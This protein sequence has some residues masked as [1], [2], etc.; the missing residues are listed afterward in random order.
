LLIKTKPET[1]EETVSAVVERESSNSKSDVASVMMEVD[2]YLAY[3]RFSQAES[4]I[5]SA[6][7]SFPESA[8]LKAKLL[9][10]YLF[11]ANREA[12]SDYLDDVHLFLSRTS[13]ALWE[14]IA[15]MGRD[16]VP[17][18]PALVSVATARQRGSGGMESPTSDAGESIHSEVVDDLEIDIDSLLDT[19][20]VLADFVD[21]GERAHTWDNGTV[22]AGD[23]PDL[24]ADVDEQAAT[25]QKPIIEELISIDDLDLTDLEEIDFDF[26][27]KQDGGT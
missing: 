9:E 14:R 6:M 16:L 22:T 11:Q 15:E 8:E 23:D 17:D 20:S 12:F 5:T 21:D 1:L 7:V 25:A 19:D 2:I 18:H 4:L 3:R 27:L 24:S 26:E 10:I 13:P